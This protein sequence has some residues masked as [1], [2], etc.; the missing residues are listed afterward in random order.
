M[1]TLSPQSQNV[2]KFTLTKS[3]GSKHVNHIR[4]LGGGT[5]DAQTVVEVAADSYDPDNDRK[6]WTTWANKDLTDSATLREAA[7]ELVNEM[8]SQY[9]EAKLTVRGVEAKLG[10]RFR[11]RYPEQDIDTDVEVVKSTKVKDETGVHYDVTL[12]TRELTRYDTAGKVV[13]D[14]ERINR[15]GG[16]QVI[17]TYDDPTDAPQE[18]GNIIYAT[19]AGTVPRGIYY[20]NGNNYEATLYADADAQ[21]V[22]VGNSFVVPVGTDQ[23]GQMVL[24][25]GTD[26]Y[27]TT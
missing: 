21:N 27:D 17:S 16:E 11:L 10:D 18:E 5:G 26:R 9:V 14:V 23:S 24:P 1:T 20:H 22:Y 3:G 6:I 4:A 8:Y 13:Q 12:S 2:E 19:G 7:K 25:T 15:S